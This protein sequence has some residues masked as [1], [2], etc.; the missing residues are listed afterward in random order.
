MN[1]HLIENLADDLIRSRRRGQPVTITEELRALDL[2]DAYR[3]QERVVAAQIS[4]GGGPIGWK[5]S[6]TQG[7][8]PTRGVLPA[9]AL[10]PDGAVIALDGS[11]G[12]LVEAELLLRVVD[13][14]GPR[15]SSDELAAAVEVAAALEIPQSRFRDWWPA[16][17]APNVTLPLLVAD[18]A[19]AF[20]VVA[21]TTWHRL[22]VAELAEVTCTLTLPDGVTHQGTAQ[23]V[24]GSPLN[25]LAWLVEDLHS[26]DL[27]V[28]RG[29]V[30]STGTF[31]PPSHAMPGRFVAEFS[32]VGA[33]SA[34]FT[35]AG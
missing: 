26:R 12:L 29:A 25:A 28:P 24:Y 11:N 35:R 32:R 4:D 10:L 1:D 15:P 5:L 27:Q 23:N 17:G 13:E 19:A 8:E 31:T 9:T 20:R 16:G 2:A 30:I 7:P 34:T 14:L 21:A 6:G 3:V 22:T 33:V 18:N